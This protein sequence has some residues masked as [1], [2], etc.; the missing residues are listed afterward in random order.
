MTVRVGELTPREARVSFGDM[1]TTPPA[2]SAPPARVPIDARLVQWFAAELVLDSRARLVEGGAGG[3]TRIDLAEV[4][5]DLPAV[6]WRGRE[7]GAEQVQVVGLLCLP[8]ASERDDLGSAPAPSRG[9]RRHRG[10]AG[11]LIVG[12]PGSGKSTASTMVAQ[13]LRR[14]QVRPQLESLPA[15][16]REP[17]REIAI[18]LDEL[19]KRIHIEECRDDLPLR[20]N[21]PDLARWMTPRDGEPLDALLW[22]YLT[23]R[24]EEHAAMFGISLGLSAS[25]FEKQARAHGEI[26]WI[27]DGLDE[28]P[29]SAGRD[30]AI[31][32]IRAA[33]STGARS[34]VIVTTRPQGY[35][36]EFGDL[37]ALV[38]T[39]MPPELAKD[40]GLRLL[41]AWSGPGD[42]Q[43]ND[44]LKLLETEFAKSE[45]QALVRS[46]LH[47]TMA[48]LLIANHGALPRAR[49]LLFEHYFDTIFKR[50]IGKD[51][52][53]G[54]Q[55]EDKQLLRTL[56]ARAGL[57]LHTRSQGSGGARPTLSRRE[58][59]ALLEA[60]LREE[61]QSAERAEAIADRM[62]RFTADRLVLLLR[63]TDG[64]YAF[65]IRS[66]QEFFAA[67]A[68]IEGEVAVVRRRLDVIALNPHWSNVLGLLVSG[69][70]VPGTGAA[71]K[72]AARDYTHALCRALND[73]SLGRRAAAV[74]VAGSRLAIAMLRET[75]RYGGPWLHEPLWEIALKAVNAPVQSQSA[76]YA[77][78]F[79][80]GDVTS[81]Q[82]DDDLE[83]HVRLSALAWTWQ[84]AD[85]DLRQRRVLRAAEEALR[86][87]GAAALAGWCLLLPALQ[88]EVPEAVRLAT[89]YAP[90]TPDAAWRLLKFVVE[91][92]GSR[93]VPWIADFA[94]AHASW[95]PPWRMTSIRAAEW[96][97]AGVFAPWMDIHPTVIR[98]RLATDLECLL[99][100]ILSETRVWSEMISPPADASAGWRAW[101][102]V[103]AFHVTPSK[104]SLA[105]ALEELADSE[106]WSNQQ[107][108]GA[109]LAWPLRACL[110][111]VDR[112]E[113]LK[114]LAALVR[115]GQL[116][117]T[118]D[119]TA[120]ESSWRTM[121]N[122]SDE[123]IATWLTARRQPWI[124]TG[125][126]CSRVFSV[127][128]VSLRLSEPAT[129][130]HEVRRTSQVLLASGGYPFVAVSWL[131]LMLLWLAHSTRFDSSNLM[132]IHGDLVPH[133][134]VA[135][136]PQ[137]PDADP[138]DVFFAID[139]LLPDLAGPDTESWYRTLDQRGR[140]GANRCAMGAMR[141]P[142]VRARVI[143]DALLSRL[144]ARPDQWGLIDAVWAALNAGPVT[145]PT[146]VQ[147]P[148]LP[149]DASPRARASAAAVRLHA[150]GVA[151][152]QV[153]VLI[154]QLFSA[155]DPTFDHRPALAQI[156][157]VVHADSEY[158][159]SVLLHMLDAATQG[160]A[161]IR[162]TVLGELFRILRRASP[163]AFATADAWKEHG[164]PGPYLSGQAPELLPPRLLRLVELSNVRLFKD[165]PDVDAPFPDP[166][167]DQGQWIVLVGE[168]GTGKTTLLRALGLAVAD[169]TVATRLLDEN[170]PFVRNGG[171]GRIAIELDTGR[172]EVAIRR[173]A[174][175][176]AV[177]ATGDASVARPWVIGYG[178]R[179]GNARGEKDRAPEWGPTGELH[180]L[181]DRPATLVNAVDWLLDLDRRVLN[182]RRQHG[183]GGED[184][185]PRVHAAIWQSVERALHALL[186]IT[187]LEP[188][189]R[190]VVVTHPEL[191]R[192]R[193]DALSDGYLTTTGW[194]IDLM[195]RWIQR[196]EDLGEAVGRD[197]LRQ[198]TGVVLIDE[199]DL[200]LHPRWQ[201]RIIDDVRRLFPRLSFVVTTHNPLTLQGARPG[202]IFIMRRGDGGRI[203]LTQRDIQPGHDVDRVLF[204]QFAIV[205]TFD[206]HTRELLKRHRD[207][208][209]RGSAAD[210]LERT[211][212]EGELAARLGRV[213]EVLADERGSDDDPSSPWN[214]QDRALLAEFA[215]GKA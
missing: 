211:Q 93:Y 118:S 71:Q 22:R 194:V 199:I 89:E 214:D 136:A 186:G 183:A 11:A 177:V 82:W 138:H 36:G 77:R 64:G 13:L 44:R 174:R 75:E 41:R 87:R 61:E 80:R 2:S 129:F 168:N 173:D 146:D 14:N 158:A 142:F 99:C 62:L 160:D 46:P 3:D 112:A 113:D 130:L 47:A 109:V 19:C 67:V 161:G 9:R 157:A 166:G 200:H 38:V 104:E 54:I 90:K 162:D 141:R 65:G 73:G 143:Q 101:Q 120:A 189:E 202:E 84:G 210:D 121:P 134:L 152:D 206:K 15:E 5:V 212:L 185:R 52:E 17:S 28:V 45:V 39:E 205:Y 32:V 201:M 154:T 6:A 96:P 66:L 128:L 110:E 10:V 24:A 79:R 176:E 60:I 187:A 91:D 56:H 207:L 179:R 144:A 117:D 108:Q 33:V 107:W 124:Q 170:Q 88:R 111:F 123:E 191:G 196:Q 69:L 29:R 175:T 167:P 18:E 78:R 209:Q 153:P 133:D 55:L 149:A 83:V 197:L 145:L 23:A 40:Y 26:L 178:V 85:A 68:L 208:L 198:M 159:A 21:L 182:E 43:L 12:G 103:V 34:G 180:T 192:V 164:L 31:S 105:E 51:G 140:I 70:A 132:E 7:P 148:V 92:L 188:E 163:L 20:V 119:W 49:Y 127:G 190:H 48:T 59:R 114:G 81:S 122:A 58:L 8:V 203:E 106:A 102:A 156:L 57:V 116:G 215:K 135:H 37:D 35:E 126:G 137:R 155:E 97:A 171:E 4:F 63:V 131:K 172:I 95:F 204:E 16:L 150:G 42:P 147:L 72:A 165:T 50:E 213:G 151:A 74:C 100:S 169:P 98:V 25:D 94:N 184:G 76:Q 30:R 86:T 195:A 27:F 115:A 139:L 125:G 1:V 181:F 193:L 53:H